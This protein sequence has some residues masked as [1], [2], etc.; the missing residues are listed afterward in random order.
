MDRLKVSWVG[1]S[2]QYVGEVVRGRSIELRN[3]TGTLLTLESTPP[4]LAHA[5]TLS[6]HYMIYVIPLTSAVRRYG[7]LTQ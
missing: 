7:Q 1:V 5:I 2:W 3:L 4:W 6:V